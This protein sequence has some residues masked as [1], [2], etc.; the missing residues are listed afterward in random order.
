ME[1]PQGLI[2]KKSY[3]KL[4]DSELFNKIETYAEEFQQ[5]LKSTIEN[6]YGKKWVLD[7][8]HQWSRQYE[9]P[10]V[11][12]KIKNEAKNME[13]ILDA[14]SG[15]TFFPYLISTAFPN[16]E[17]HAC[18][19]DTKLKNL[20]TKANKT[21]NTDIKFTACDMRN[22]PYSNESFNLI[23]CVS[24]LEHT[25]NYEEIIKEFHRILNKNGKFI[26]TFDIS[27]DGLSEISLLKVEKFLESLNK[28]FSPN[29]KFAALNN[30]KNTEIKEV[31]TSD[32]AKNT[33]GKHLLPWKY[34][35]LKFL[36]DVV[37]KRT[38]PKKFHKSLGCFCLIL[39]R[40]DI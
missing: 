17:I 15:F 13:K 22:T 38:L 27:F 16:L 19:F 20:Y 7:S 5:D 1:L 4:L 25:D 3:Q 9:Y 29:E 8:F 31:F 39:N 28:Y 33:Y 18:D 36:Y 10:F 30:L 23:Y 37:K 35:K 14:G 26:V 40:K 24:V 34:P 2:T 21:Y 12:S 32:F 11:Y 6:Y